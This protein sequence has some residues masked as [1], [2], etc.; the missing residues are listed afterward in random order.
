MKSSFKALTYIKNKTQLCERHPGELFHRWWGTVSGA[1]AEEMWLMCRYE[2][3]CHRHKKKRFRPLRFHCAFLILLF[4]DVQQI[5][6]DGDSLCLMYNIAEQTIKIKTFC[7][8]LWS[9]LSQCLSN[10]QSLFILSFPQWLGE[11]WYFSF[12]DEEL[13]QSK[14]WRSCTKSDSAFNRWV[15]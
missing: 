14:W 8:Y 13:R 1:M 12:T 6:G 9:G 3:F 5:S 11:S 4:L 15:Y 10:L 2:I 7:I